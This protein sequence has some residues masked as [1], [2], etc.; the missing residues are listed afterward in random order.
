M[1]CFRLT[2]LIGCGFLSIPA[3]AEEGDDA[4]EDAAKETIVYAVRS[5]PPTE[6]VQSVKQLFGDELQ[7]VASERSN[8][9]IVRCPAAMRDEVLKVLETVDP[10]HRVLTVQVLFLA[11][12]EKPAANLSGLS[13]PTEK[14]MEAIQALQRDGQIA[15][16]DRIEVTTL[17]NQPTLMQIGQRK[18]RVVGETVT[19]TGQ[20]VKQYQDVNVGTLLSLT[21][22]VSAENHVA[23][24]LKFAKSEL[25]ANKDGDDSA[26]ASVITAQQQT[27]IKLGDGEARLI[28]GVTT[29]DPD[30]DGG[31]LVVSVH[32]RKPGDAR[33]PSIA[34]LGGGRSGSA[35]PS[36]GSFRPSTGR[37]SADRERPS[38]Q[39]YV[40]MMMSRYDKNKDDVLDADEMKEMRTPLTRADA[41]DD[42]NVS[43]EELT[44]YLTQPRRRE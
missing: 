35:R 8:S 11:A 3:L 30:S 7:I 27:T 12:G 6:I 32:V 28:S 15:I 17:N 43:K 2:L 9:V 16:T 21:G 20:S 36:G 13:G 4:K 34:S 19:R 10:P 42:G 18:A 41:D 33:I 29:N 31:M 38:P 44:K 24:N 39:R 37:G 40:D 5:V 23:L 1:R 25:A 14:V 22:Q 26:P